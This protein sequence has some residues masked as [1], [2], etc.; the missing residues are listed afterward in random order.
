MELNLVLSL[1]TT[2]AVMNISL[3]MHILMTVDHS[4]NNSAAAFL[5]YLDQY[6]TN[7][8]IITIGSNFIP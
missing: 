4:D 6:S 3:V 7:C 5:D 1:S 2:G 8:S